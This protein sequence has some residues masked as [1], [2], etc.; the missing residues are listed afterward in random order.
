[1]TIKINY[2]VQIK[3]VNGEETQFFVVIIGV[4]GLDSTGVD[5]TTHYFFEIDSEPDSFQVRELI[6][7]AVEQ[8]SSRM[9]TLH[10]L[11]KEVDPSQYDYYPLDFS[12]NK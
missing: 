8:L 7:E 5:L 6:L 9:Y 12:K 3:D 10:R 4:S 1:M 11:L 2:G